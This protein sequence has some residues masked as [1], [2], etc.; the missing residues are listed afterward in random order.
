MSKEYFLPYNEALAANAIKSFN[1]VGR[2]LTILST[3]GAADIYVQIGDANE[4]QIPAGLS[5]ELPE[6]E[7]FT[8]LR[9]RN[10]EG[11]SITLKFSVSNGR[12]FDNR[13]VISGT[14]TTTISGTAAT[15]ETLANTISTP[16]SVSVA[17]TAP[18]SPQVAASSTN[19]EVH[20][21][22]NGSFDLWWGD[23]NVDGANNRGQKIIPGGKEIIAGTFA[24]YFRANGGTTT[25]SIAITTKP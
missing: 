24:I 1:V 18:G 5:I 17:T 20:V 3:T 14:V 6:G 21:Q 2:F 22:N 9:F 19:R 8:K 12:V 16:A 13:N 7:E 10:S 11:S 4:Q 15:L 25:A 23:S